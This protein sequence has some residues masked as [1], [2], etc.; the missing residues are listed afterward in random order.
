MTATASSLSCSLSKGTSRRWTL[1][2]ACRP[3]SSGRGTTTF[4]LRRPGR[5]RAGSSASGRFVAARSST[6]SRPSKPSSS[7]SSW[8]RVWSRSS[9]FP[10]PRFMP[11]ASSSSINTTQGARLR[12][13]A[14]SSRT[15]AAPRPTKSSTNSEAE[16]AKKGTPASPA[17]ALASSVFPVP[18]GPDSSTPEGILALS[19]LYRPASLRH[20][21][22]SMSSILGTST[23]ATSLKVM[24]G[25][26]GLSFMACFLL[27]PVRLAIMLR[28]RKRKGSMGIQIMNMVTSTLD[29]AAPNDVFTPAKLTS[30]SLRMEE[31][32]V[33]FTGR[34]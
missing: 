34:V 20:A 5:S 3:I 14:K 15:R 28:R 17:T 16:A 32:S 8:L 25:A 31:T 11:T 26:L 27:P 23:P 24:S 29:T 30:P 10:K 9:L 1:R 19:F 13:S 2:M 22:V 18:G 21:T 12:A 4:R 6:P 7:V 33:F